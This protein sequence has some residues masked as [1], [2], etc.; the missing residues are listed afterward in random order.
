[1][2]EEKSPFNEFNWDSE[3]TDVDFFGEIQKIQEE[4]PEEE[5]KKEEEKSKEEEIEEEK[6]F[7]DLVE[8]QEEN[9]SET[10]EKPSTGLKDSLQ[11]LIEQ[12]IIELDENEELPESVDNDYLTDIIDKS[13]EK[14]FEESIKNLPEDLKNIIK[15]VN[16][17][18]SLE[19][20]ITILSESSELSEDIDLSDESNQEKVL[21]YLLKQEGEDDEIIEA[22]IEFLKDSGKLAAISEKKFEKWKND[23]KTEL[24]M[25]VENQKKQKQLLKENQIKFKKDISEYLS[26]NNEIKGLTISKNEEKELPS[27]I[28]DTSIKLQDGRQITPF[29]RDLFEA[30]KDREKIIALAKIIKSDFDFSSMKKNIVTKQTQK[31]KEEIQRQEKS[32]DKRSSQK[33]RLIDLL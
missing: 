4:V 5:E 8:E 33:T 24:E 21:R 23:K 7:E 31:L 28:S 9:S 32:T 18:G 30:L 2:N 17:G 10:L 13:I 27:Y 15:Y 12:G 11:Y 6:I 20:I 3:I 1:M 25:E 16:N 19:D 22:N 14:R 26:S 29:Y